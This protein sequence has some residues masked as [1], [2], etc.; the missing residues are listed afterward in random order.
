MPPKLEKA[1]NQPDEDSLSNGE[2]FMIPIYLIFSIEL[3]LKFSDGFKY[4]HDLVAHE[5]LCFSKT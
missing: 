1:S 3:L 5:I 4:K 2:P